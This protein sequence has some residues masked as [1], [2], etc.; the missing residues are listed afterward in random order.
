M[1]SVLIHGRTSDS[2]VMI[3][4]SIINLKEYLSGREAVIITDSNV[5]RHY[6]D[7]FPSDKIIRIGTGEEI[8]NLNT[9]KDI[10]GA[11][12]GME[13]D[14]NA[15]IVGIGGG[16]VCDIAGFAASIYERGLKFGFVSTTLLAQVDASV[17]GKNG[18]NFEGYKNMVGT[19]NQ[20][21]FVICDPDLLK[22]LPEKEILNGCAEIIKHAAIADLKMFRYLENNYQ[23][24]LSLEKS[25]IEKVVHNSILIKSKIVN[26]D[27][28]ETGERRKLNFGHT[29][30]HA[31]EKVS[32]VSH[33]EAVSAGMAASAMISEKMGYLT[34]KERDKI[35]TLLKNMGLPLSIQVDREKFLDAIGKDKKRDKN[36]IHFVLLEKIGKAIVQDIIINDLHKLISL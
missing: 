24:I 7:V 22:T 18:V 9:I 19:F 28:R 25:V 34:D 5:F 29:L 21:E 33:G 36:R 2:L 23:G 6:R 4:E 14:R 3:G 27:E 26:M 17:G 16:V 12:I 35:E 11:L 32:G 8:K 20:P 13:V 10:I 31:F 30:G 1:E 15:L